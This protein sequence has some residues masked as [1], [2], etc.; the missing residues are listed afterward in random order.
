MEPTSG[1]TAAAREAAPSA[2]NESADNTVWTRTAALPQSVQS[3]CPECAT[4][5]AHSSK[6]EGTET[7]GGQSIHH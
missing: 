5:S 2:L 7:N 6:T 4:V 1:R 3:S